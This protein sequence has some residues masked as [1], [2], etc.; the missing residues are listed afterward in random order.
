MKREK[1]IS[2]AE[3]AK[4]L[5]MTPGQFQAQV[6]KC[7]GPVWVQIGPRKSMQL[8]R[9]SLTIRPWKAKGK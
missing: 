4:V 3:A 9:G 7:T 6:D 2:H 5:G 1:L 8:D